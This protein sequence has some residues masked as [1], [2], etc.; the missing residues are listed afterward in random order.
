[1]P[2]RIV[3]SAESRKR[4]GIAAI[5][6]GREEPPQMPVKKKQLPGWWPGS[7][8]KTREDVRT[9][10]CA[11]IPAGLSEQGPRRNTMALAAHAMGLPFQRSMA[12]GGRRPSPPA[13]LFLFRQCNPDG[14]LTTS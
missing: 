6:G 5:I 12:A 13:C 1:M 10:P 2:E 7:G 3:H 11:G 8:R 4:R 14:E 9:K